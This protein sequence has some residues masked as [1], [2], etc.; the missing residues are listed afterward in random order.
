MERLREILAVSLFF[1]GIFLVINACLGKFDLL[2]LI[3]GCVCL[4]L[5][6]FIWPSK[7]NSQRE[8]NFYLDIIEIAIELPFDILLWMF[9]FLIR[10][11]RKADLPDADL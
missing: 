5:A 10:I 1:M 8:D 6:Y 3:S 7:K 9:R 2:M 11:F 4:L